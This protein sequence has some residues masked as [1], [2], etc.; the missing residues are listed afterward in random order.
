[1][2]RLPNYQTNNIREPVCFYYFYT[3]FSHVQTIHSFPTTS[4]FTLG[5]V[6]KCVGV[7]YGPVTILNYPCQYILLH[8][9]N[10]CRQLQ[11]SDQQS[12]RCLQTKFIL[13][14]ASRQTVTLHVCR[15]REEG[16][17]CLCFTKILQVMRPPVNTP[18]RHPWCASGDSNWY[19]CI[20]LNSHPV[21][22]SSQIAL[23]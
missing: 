11:R 3:Y 17:K 21:S 10:R 20:F 13:P 18:K 8:P 15:N 9:W 6:I 5:Y 4:V 1:M 23:W 19:H 2:F 14:H 16:C 7:F 22:I 12:G